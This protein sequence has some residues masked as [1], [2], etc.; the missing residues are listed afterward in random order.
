M[1]T[2]VKT[3]ISRV[4]IGDCHGDYE[5]LMRLIN[6]LPKGIPLTFVGDLID[7][8]EDSYKVVEFVK[9]NGHDCVMGNH[10]E[11]MIRSI[12][13]QEDER[14]YTIDE[15][16]GWYQFNGGFQTLESYVDKEGNDDVTSLKEH[17]EWMKDLPI[18]IEY[19][20]L[21][22]KNGKHLLVSHSTPEEVWHKRHSTDPFELEQFKY[23][24]M[25]DRKSMPA[26]IPGAYSVYGHTP[27][28]NGPTVKDHF[29]CIDT[30]VYMVSN[31]KYGRIT[32]LQFP[33]M[34]VYEEKVKNE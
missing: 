33:E 16:T 14:P 7:R 22:D 3:G 32:A 9:N 25:W 8:G 1:M 31:P 11:M 23:R 26:K 4:V 27:Q 10:E 5:T 6:K 29:A 34:I 24:V 21:K 18:Y 30:G 28:E 17:I 19:P 13:F 12:I 15:H 20:E 2:S